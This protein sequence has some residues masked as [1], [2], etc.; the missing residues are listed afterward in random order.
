MYPNSPASLPGAHYITDSPRNWGASPPDWRRAAGVPAGVPAAPTMSRITRLGDGSI[1]VSAPR[2]SSYSVT[3]G[4]PDMSV[5]DMTP[6]ITSG[7]TMTMGVITQ[8]MP[9]M[10]TFIGII[11]AIMLLRFAIRSFAK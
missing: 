8:F 10:L 7:M 1:L 6:S 4:S 2:S 9:M 11:M 5:P 3:P